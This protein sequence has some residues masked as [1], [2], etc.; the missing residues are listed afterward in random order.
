MNDPELKEMIHKVIFAVAVA[1]VF[2][3]PLF[4]IF[5][6]KILIEESSI[7]KD[8]R[9]DK[10]LIIYITKDDCK[11]CKTL[12]KELDKKDIEYKELNKDKNKDYNEI[13]RNLDLTK[14]ELKEPTLIYI[15][16]G[17]VISYIVDIKNKEYLNK[18]LEN[19]K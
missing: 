1:V 19:Y 15:E 18:Y 9:N 5:K 16:K 12:E 17:K 10:S 4:L 2:A 3:V 7:L 8:I 14:S 6:N 13:I 11:I